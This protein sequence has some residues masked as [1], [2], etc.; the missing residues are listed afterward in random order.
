MHKG[1]QYLRTQYTQVRVS[2][3]K[4]GKLKY[5]QKL[6]CLSMYLRLCFDVCPPVQE[7]LCGSEV[8]FISSIVK[9]GGPNLTESQRQ[10]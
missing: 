2:E 8:A 1:I 4:K 9:S 5:N 7:D 6:L 10:N 3:Y